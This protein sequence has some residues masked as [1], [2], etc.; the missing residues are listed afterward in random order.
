MQTFAILWPTFALVALTFVVLFWVFAARGG[1]MRRNPP[2]AD[3]FASAEASTRYFQP[4]E[5]PANNLR[6]LFELP[7][8]YYALVALLIVTRQASHIQVT[9][10]WGFVILRVAHSFAHLVL[11]RVPVRALAFWL[12]ALLLLAMW[13]GFAVD[14]SRAQE[15]YDD[16]MANITI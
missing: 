2:T 1:H 8:L 15:T 6:N 7:I 11:R 13:I 16:A 10:A 4:V 9:L 3:D 12:S 5:M 14:V